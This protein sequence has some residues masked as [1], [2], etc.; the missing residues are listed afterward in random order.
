MFFDIFLDF[1]FETVLFGGSGG[2]SLEQL[3]G[4][5]QFKVS[6][7]V[8]AEKNDSIKYVYYM[9]TSKLHLN[10]PT[11]CSPLNSSRHS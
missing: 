7:C 4:L 6:N 11:E 8:S 1:V 5:E 10:V 3:R 9:K 2:W